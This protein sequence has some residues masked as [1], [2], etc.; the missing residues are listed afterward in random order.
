MLRMNELNE[1]LQEDLQFILKKAT[2]LVDM[3]LGVTN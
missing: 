2:F 1:S 3:M